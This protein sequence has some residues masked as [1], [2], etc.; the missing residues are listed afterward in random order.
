MVLFQGKLYSGW[1]LQIEGICGIIKKCLV[2][3]LCLKVKI[4]GGLIVLRSIVDSL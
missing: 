2:V 4:T 3:F 1:D